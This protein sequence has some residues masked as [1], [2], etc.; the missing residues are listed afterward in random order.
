M[1]KTIVI[2]LVLILAVFVLSAQS[3]VEKQAGSKL[4]EIWERGVLLVGT[5]G[6]Y[7]PISYLDPQMIQ[8]TIS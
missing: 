8:A 1:R 7:Q 6:D 5:A 3:I 2:I 4:E